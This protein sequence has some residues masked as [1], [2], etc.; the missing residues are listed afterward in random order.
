[1]FCFALCCMFLK[2]LYV[3]HVFFYT[4]FPL[5]ILYFYTTVPATTITSRNNGKVYN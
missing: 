1:M 2:D 3:G 4:D 5:D